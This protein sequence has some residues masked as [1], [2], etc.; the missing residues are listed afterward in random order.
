MALVTIETMD[1]AEADMIKDMM[2]SLDF[3]TT[4]KIEYEDEE[5]W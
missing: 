2:A 3:R 4:V 1:D 5:S